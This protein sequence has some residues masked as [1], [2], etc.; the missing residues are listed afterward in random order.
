MNAWSTAAT[1][2]NDCR[3]RWRALL[4][5][6][7][8]WWIASTLLLAPL[9]AATLRLAI[10]GSGQSVLADQDLLFFVTSPIGLAGLVVVGVMATAI[11]ALEFGA[12]LTILSQP[13]ESPNLL[14]AILLLLRR[15]ARLL[16]VAAKIVLKVIL[17]L[18]PAV[19]IAAAT[20]AL[21][22]TKFDINYYLSQ[23]PPSFWMAAIVAVCL[24]IYVAIAA[25]KLASDW[26]LVLPITL[27]EDEASWRVAALSRERT[28][29]H[30]WEVRAWILG[31]AIGSF[32]LSAATTLAIG[33]AAWRIAPHWPQSITAVAIGVGLG[34]TLAVTAGAAVH[35]VETVALAAIVR[36]LYL[37]LGGADPETLSDHCSLKDRASYVTRK[38]IAVGVPVALLGAATLGFVMLS[39]VSV[40]DRVLVIAHRG[41]PF[42]APDN[43]L[44]AVRAAIAEGADW[45]EIDVQETADGEV[46]VFHDSDFMKAAGVNLK[47]WDATAAQLADIDIGTP[48][49]ADFAAERAP[50]LRAVL[51][52]CRDKA[53]VLVELKY[54]GHDVRLEER[55][56]EIVEEAGMV[57]QTKFMSL[58]RNGVAKLK[59]LRPEWRVGQLLSVTAG[60][61]RRLEGD[62]LAV[63]ASFATRELIQKTHRDGRELYVWTVNDPM[64]MSALISRGVDG[65]I[66]DVPAA[67]R[68]VLAER[69]DMPPVSRLLV[70]LADRFRIPPPHKPNAILDS[71]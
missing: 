13:A 53:G 71:P 35:L 56:V 20:Y 68:A 41:S 67:A 18:A 59:A 42:S 55:V 19:A 66:T 61:A 47:I 43:T 40:E 54:Y 49:S 15:A 8:V 58:N 2:W 33:A 50:T 7:V 51:D 69:D 26:V 9:Y 64:T 17:W 32:L 48:F 10:A 39:S 16:S 29:L 3:T 36:R 46:V 38:R 37:R 63:N 30:R 34:L 1:A 24:S 44:A 23:R 62:F 52:E 12:L 28:A 5:V 70:D 4:G 65:L 14:A 27:F 11:V 22:L 21:L 45:V 60:S 57:D 6:G 25:V 31:W